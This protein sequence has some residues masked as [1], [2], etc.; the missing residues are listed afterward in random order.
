MGNLNFKN[1]FK[2]Q[3]NYQLLKI[4][5]GIQN[6]RRCQGQVFMN[7]DQIWTDYLKEKK[8]ANR[9]GLFKVVY[10]IKSE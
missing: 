3:A 5:P 10:I 8:D 7:V 6:L 1:D 4:K 9:Y 2:K